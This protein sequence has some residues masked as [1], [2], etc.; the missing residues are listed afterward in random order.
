MHSATGRNKTLTHA[1]QELL[2][3]TMWHTSLRACR[4]IPEGRPALQLTDLEAE[5]LRKAFLSHCKLVGADAEAVAPLLDYCSDLSQNQPGP[6][7]ILL[8]EIAQVGLAVTCLT[9]GR[10]RC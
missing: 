10:H 2:A 8:D 5:E 3:T 6:L 4:P 1:Y 7:V 9:S